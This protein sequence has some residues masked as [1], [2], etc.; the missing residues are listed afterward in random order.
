ME[1]PAHSSDADPVTPRPNSSLLILTQIVERILMGLVCVHRKNSGIV[2]DGLFISA[3][4]KS[5]YVKLVFDNSSFHARTTPE[6]M[7]C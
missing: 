2:L 5:A 3:C 4:V 1:A 6:Q 7:Q